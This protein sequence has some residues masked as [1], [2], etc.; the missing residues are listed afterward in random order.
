MHLITPFKTLTL[1]MITL[2]LAGCTSDGHI[3]RWSQCALIGAGTG[4]LVGA[5]VNGSSDRGKSAAYGAL[6]GAL[7]VSAICAITGRDSD[8]DGVPDK[9]DRCPDTPGGISVDHSGCPVDSDNDGVPDYMDKCANTPYGA[10]VDING[11]PDSDNDGVP[12]NID[13]C[14]DTPVNLAV[15]QHGCPTDS[16]GDGVPNAVDKCPDTPVGITVDADGCPLQKE[17]GTVYFGFDKVDI[18]PQG[19]QELD[20]IAEV[21]KQHAGIRLTAVGYTDSTGPLEYNR[22]LALHRAESVKQ[23]LQERGVSGDRIRAV[24][25]GVLETGDQT[26]KG[27]SNNRHVTI[28]IEE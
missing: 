20:Q 24:A 17:L 5:A 14:P 8:H 28:T 19:R 10:P 25:G 16:D 26:P 13:R 22:Q 18:D 6:G 27:R 21:A 11:C 3:H 9:K 15:D 12:D 23:Y 2:F 7:V 1:F 4:G